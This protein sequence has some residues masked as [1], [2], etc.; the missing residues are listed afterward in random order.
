[1]IV[2][3]G[4]LVDRDTIETFS[5]RRRQPRCRFDLHHFHPNFLNFIR[6]NELRSLQFIGELTPADTVTTWM[7]PSGVARILPFPILR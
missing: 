6:P 2:A 4:A 7:N 5:S 3:Q 1:M